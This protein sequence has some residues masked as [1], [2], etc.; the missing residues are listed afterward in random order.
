MALLKTKNVKGIEANYWTITTL[1]WSK[2]S[3]KTYV[4]L[5]LF[6]NEDARKQSLDNALDGV[7]FE[8][9][10]ELSRDECYLKIKES[11]LV[12]RITKEKSES[13]QDGN[14][15]IQEEEFEMVETNF[16]IDAIDK[17]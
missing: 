7:G 13:F 5:T 2:E 4:A 15:I 14:I 1:T 8:F 3:D 17:W 12:K 11:M 10:G 6:Y 16:F 9:E